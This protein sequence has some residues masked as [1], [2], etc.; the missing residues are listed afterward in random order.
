MPFFIAFLILSITDSSTATNIS[1][2]ASVLDRLRDEL[3]VIGDYLSF[4]EQCTL[5]LI[6]HRFNRVLGRCHHVIQH[7]LQTLTLL[8][9][10]ILV[11]PEQSDGIINESTL[12]N[13]QILDDD[14]KYNELY[15]G[16][17]PQIIRNCIRKRHELKSN[18]SNDPIPC[19]D[20]TYFYQK[21]F[22]Y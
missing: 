2:N 9:D 10:R 19:C 1:S 8:M 15:I 18:D 21:V 11:D 14:L 16:S 7:K 22:F 17:W 6:N 20:D 12:Q 4:R 3:E 13:I 5:R